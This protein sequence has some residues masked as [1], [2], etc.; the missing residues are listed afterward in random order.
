[1]AK[2]SPYHTITPEKDKPGH[3]DVYHD[4]DD[5][6]DG[7]RILPQDKRSGTAGRPRCDECIGLG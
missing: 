3:R 5:C 2:V 1:M 7:R 6:S 4:H